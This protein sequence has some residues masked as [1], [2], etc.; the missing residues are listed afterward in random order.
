MKTQL[1]TTSLQCITHDKLSSVN[2]KNLNQ[3]AI[4]REMRINEVAEKTPRPQFEPDHS[5]S[6]S[7]TKT[8]L[9]RTTMVLTL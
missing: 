8:E 5:N 6:S 2:L 9:T 3:T 4:D 1:H 7:N